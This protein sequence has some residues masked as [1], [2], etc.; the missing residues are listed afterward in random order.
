MARSGSQSVWRMVGTT[1]VSLET[2]M[3]SRKEMTM[4]RS[5][6]IELGLMWGWWTELSSVS[7]SV[8]RL[9]QMMEV[10][11]ETRMKSRKEMTMVQRWEMEYRPTKD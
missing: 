2:R 9:V 8:W 3:E 11:L 7:Q 4:A 1:E 10:S 5:W 6:E